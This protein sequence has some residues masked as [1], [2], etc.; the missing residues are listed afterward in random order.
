MLKRLSPAR[1]R[2][3]EI[4][5]FDERVAGLGMRQAEKAA[6]LAEL[7]DREIAA[8]AADADRLASWQLDGEQGPRPAPELPEIRRQ[9]RQRQ[10]E[11]EALTRATER[12]LADKAAFVHEHRGRLVKDADS[13]ADDAHRRYLDLID[14]LAEARAELAASRR[15]T[16][17][18]RLYPNREAGTEPPDQLAGGRRQPLEAMG[19]TA[20]VAPNRVLDAL[21]ADA[22]WLRQAATPEQKAL[23]GEGR[24]PRKPPATEWS[25][26]PKRGRSG[27]R[28]P[29]T[30]YG[31]GDLQWA[32][33]TPTPS[34]VGTYAP[35]G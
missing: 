10:E 19:L 23:M 18:A 35:P 22:D 20:S 21:K 28:G 7:R 6:E 17:W 2:W 8:Q 25:D 24:D 1:N 34:S 9:I 29:R 5:E 26:T 15:S 16:V 31:A 27:T 30:G 3:P 11:W 14:Q 32:P 13:H 4:A 33:R 12:V